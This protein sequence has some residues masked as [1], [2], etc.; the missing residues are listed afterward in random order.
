[1]K[2]QKKA[3]P[4]AKPRGLVEYSK[5]AKP[6]HAV[7]PAPP[8]KPKLAPSMPPARFPAVSNAKTEAVEL[9][10]KLP[11]DATLED[12]QHHLYVLVKIKQGQQRLVSEGGISQAV[13][14]Q[15]LHAIASRL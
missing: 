13:M 5:V 3:R 7:L 8:L 12:I 10:K 6:P 2:L 9:I 14:E 4:G 11:D 15:D 1:L